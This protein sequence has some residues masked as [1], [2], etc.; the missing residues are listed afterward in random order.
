LV[1]VILTAPR[2]RDA[3][4]DE[5]PRPSVSDH[6]RERATFGGGVRDAPSHDRS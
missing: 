4:A 1:K 6:A 5:E 2:F 3:R